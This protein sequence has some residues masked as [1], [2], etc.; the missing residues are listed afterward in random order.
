[1]L[2]FNNDIVRCASNG[3]KNHLVS[4]QVCVI[5]LNLGILCAQSKIDITLTLNNL[6]SL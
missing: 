3:K 2:T 6:T 1:M 4:V 5:V